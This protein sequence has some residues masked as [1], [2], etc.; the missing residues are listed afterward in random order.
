MKRIRKISWALAIVGAISL[1]AVQCL[2]QQRVGTDGHAQDASQYVGASGLNDTAGNHPQPGVLGNAIVNGDVTGGKSFMGFVPYSDPGA[3]TGALAP[4]PSEQLIQNGTGVTTGGTV[5]NNAGN[6]RLFYGDSRGAPPPPGFVQMGSNGSY[7]QSPLIGTSLNDTRI[8][9]NIDQSYS[10]S[11]LNNIMLLPGPLN[12]DTNSQSVITASPLTGVR[13]LSTANTADVSYLN[14]ASGIATSTSPASIQ[15]QQ[16]LS[17]T[18][19]RQQ[20]QQELAIANGMPMT[21]INGNP[22]NRAPITQLPAPT[23]NANPAVGTLSN[24]AS[25]TLGA[26]S[27]NTG[28]AGQGQALNQPLNQQQ[29]QALNQ[30]LNTP[31]TS[32]A[33]AGATAQAN[34]GTR[35]SL[36]SP[37]KQSTQ[38]AMLRRRLEQQLG[39]NA[40]PAFIDAYIYNQQVRERQGGGT[41]N[42]TTPGIQQPGV[43]QPGAQQPGT[44]TPGGNSPSGNQPGLNNQQP[45]G[46]P[47]AQPGNSAAQNQLKTPPP[48]IDSLATGINSK[49]LKQVMSEAEGDMHDGRWVS[50]MDQYDIAEQLAPNNPLVGL[51]R[52]Y[53][54]LGASY[55]AQADTHLRQALSSDPTLLMGRFDLMKML[56]K[57]RVDYIVSDL[58]GLASND[59]HSPRP[60]F[61]L[62]YIYYNLGDDAVANGYLGLAEK[63]S[64]GDPIYKMLRDRWQLSQP[65]GQTK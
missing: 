60:V 11:S 36:V 63:R 39:P 9:T 14:S 47:A 32:G 17:I 54:E 22:I 42:G 7:I 13:T 15:Q 50:A 8:G 52:S 40:N 27:A 31:E 19:M 16:A 24:S 55:Y 65:A 26:G 61:L 1:G 30:P 58:K 18:Q 35:F 20:V 12:P 38:Y 21:D 25:G 2:A 4:R 64:G 37:V 23:L 5:I 43:Q 49:T 10:S 29:N 28:T 62:A 33:A 59:Q 53:A 44:V 46:L 48:T 34:S 51:G 57:D 56:G 3:F 45:G 6:L 41:N